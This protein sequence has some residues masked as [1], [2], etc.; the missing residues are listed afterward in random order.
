MPR[1][2]I[3]KRQK[4]THFEASL[5]SGPEAAEGPRMPLSADAKLQKQTHYS[6]SPSG[7]PEA[8]EG[9]RVAISS[10][11]E[12]AKTNPLTSM[13]TGNRHQRRRAKALATRRR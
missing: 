6:A 13:F 11:T 9:P 10:T 4:Q 1:L 5:R 3:E 8:A 7:R 2:S 12:N